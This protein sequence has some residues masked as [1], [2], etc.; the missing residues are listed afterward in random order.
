MRRILGLQ[1]CLQSVRPTSRTSHMLSGHLWL[2]YTRA[3][4][5]GFPSSTHLERRARTVFPIWGYRAD[6]SFHHPLLVL[7]W[8][9]GHGR[10]YFRPCTVDNA[11]S[12]EL[13]ADGS[14]S[15]SVFAQ[16]FTVFLWAWFR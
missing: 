14:Q 1:D 6:F 5:I 16:V 15:C 10:F 12:S 4:F 13:I 11:R 2:S 8:I 3:G 9:L 7:V